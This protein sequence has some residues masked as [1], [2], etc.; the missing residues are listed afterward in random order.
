MYAKFRLDKR[1]YVL[2]YTEPVLFIKHAAVNMMS[3]PRIQS[4]K[5][6]IMANNIS[7]GTTLRE[8]LSMVPDATNCKVP[9]PRAL[10]EHT[11]MLIHLD[12]AD[13]T[14]E[15]YENGF[16][17]YTVGRR[18]TVGRVHECDG[19]YYYE[20]V[21]G[22]KSVISRDAWLNAPFPVRLA[23]EGD[24]RLEMNADRRARKYMRS[25]DAFDF[26]PE[27]FL[28]SDDNIE[29]YADNAAIRE[30]LCALT[31]NQCEIIE[32]IFNQGYSQTDVA[33]MKGC[34]KPSVSESLERAR[35]RLK[36][37]LAKTA[38]IIF[39]VPSFRS[40]P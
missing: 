37:L 3:L 36:K 8:L 33:R 32:L 20:F 19:S 34:S 13:G 10:R 30:A 26:E 35:K 29:S 25:Y 18:Q 5:D 6:I 12:F 9:T 21:N 16:F 23:I 38:G 7:H 40:S 14:L 39:T 27:A 15:V 2:P 17:I 28:H 24:R 22:E 1:I 11:V 31:P 4:G